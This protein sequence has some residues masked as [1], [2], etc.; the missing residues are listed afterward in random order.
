LGYSHGALNIDSRDSHAVS[1]NYMVD[2]TLDLDSV[3]G[4]L[5][6]PTRRDILRRVTD[7]ELSVGD[8]ARSYNLTFA[9]ISKHLQILERAKL[10]IK[11]RQGKRQFV[12]ASPEALRDVSEYLQQYQKLWE[13]RFDALENL[14]TQEQ[15]KNKGGSDGRK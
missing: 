13:A 10:V 6:D 15:H 4:S 7:H 8:V 5:A 1:F 2:Y 11:R 3:F 14:L 9:A 12:Q